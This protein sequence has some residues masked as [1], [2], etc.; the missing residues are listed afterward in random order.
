MH[1]VIAKV[2]GIY[3]AGNLV[4]EEGGE[5][6]EFVARFCWFANFKKCNCFHKIEIAGNA[7][8]ANINS[9]EGFTKMFQLIYEEGGYFPKQMYNVAETGLFWKG[10]L[11]QTYTFQEE[12]SAC[13]FKAAKDC[14]PLLLMDN[15]EWGYKLKPPSGLPLQKSLDIEV[16]CERLF[17]CLLLLLSKELYNKPNL[18]NLIYFQAC[19][20]IEA[21]CQK[22]T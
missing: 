2:R 8:P 18:L 19:M 7:A 6:E 10:M 15:T 12:R 4:A 11:L 21:Y 22:E 20:R 16:L 3:S 5:T 13:R 17:A 1:R 14:L 9:A